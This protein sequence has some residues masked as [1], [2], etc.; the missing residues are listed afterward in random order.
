[1][2]QLCPSCSAQMEDD[3]V[4]CWCVN[5][6][7]AFDG[8]VDLATGRVDDGASDIE[9]CEACTRGECWDCGMQTWC[10]C[11]CAGPDGCYAFDPA[12]EHA[13]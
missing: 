6:G 11:D 4:W 8:Y 10:Q 1:M 3:G 2:K 9:M 13:P 7:C 5:G 12:E